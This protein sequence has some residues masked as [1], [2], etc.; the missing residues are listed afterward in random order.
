LGS[1]VEPAGKDF[2]KSDERAIAPRL[3]PDWARNVRRATAGGN[4]G[5]GGL[6]VIAGLGFRRGIAMT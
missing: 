1:L 5:A 2:A 6:K 4:A 3:T